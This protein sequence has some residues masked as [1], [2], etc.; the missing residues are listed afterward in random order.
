MFSEMQNT[1]VEDSR[2]YHTC[3]E[4][5]DSVP[6]GGVQSGQRAVA[7][8]QGCEQV[9]HLLCTQGIRELCPQELQRVCRLA[10]AEPDS[11]GSLRSSAGPQRCLPA[12]E[13][14]RQRVEGRAGS[15]GRHARG[16]S[17]NRAGDLS[18]HGSCRQLCKAHLHSDGVAHYEVHRCERLSAG[19][20]S[21]AGQD[22]AQAVRTHP[23]GLST[24]SRSARRTKLL[25]S[26]RQEDCGQRGV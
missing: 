6:A 17:F 19:G 22:A 26:A 23:V 20:G 3:G 14:Q 15:G 7:S 9:W 18:R 25:S 4:Q 24:R 21:D 12:A 1:S 10:A 5:W 2:C 11:Q 13:V 16:R 8:K